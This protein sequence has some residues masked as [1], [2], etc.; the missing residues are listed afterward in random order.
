MTDLNFLFATAYTVYLC[1]PHF[2]RPCFGGDLPVC[3]NVIRSLC[4]WSSKSVINIHMGCRPGAGRVNTQKL[5]QAIQES[6][7]F[8]TLPVAFSQL[9]APSSV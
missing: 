3:T 8:T 1:E 9:A 2:E 4:L 6:G 5:S 7:P